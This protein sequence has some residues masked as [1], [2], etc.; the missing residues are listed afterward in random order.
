M[1]C[2]EL[3]TCKSSLDNTVGTRVVHAFWLGVQSP[4]HIWTLG[5]TDLFVFVV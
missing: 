4:I 2:W 1:H 3:V 5:K